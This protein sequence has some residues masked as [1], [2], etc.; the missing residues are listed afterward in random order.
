VYK[1]MSDALKRTGRP[2]VF[3]LCQY[4]VTSVWTWGAQAGGNLWRTSGDIEANYNSIIALGFGQNAGLERFAGPG[5]WN[6]PDMLE[7]GNGKLTAEE[8]RLHM[9]LWAMLAAPLL[10]GNDLAHMN[11]A[12]LSVLT[13]REVLAIDQDPLGVQGHRIWQDGPIDVWIKP[14]ADGSRAVGIF[15]KGDPQDPVTVQFRSLGI[16]KFA[17]VRD[18]WAEKDLGRFENSFTAAVPVHGVV[19]LRMR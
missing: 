6:D 19:L 5:H 3:S 9:S 7:V 1:K 8:N 10:A 18:L 11:P 4:G 15:N 14:L 2:I 16:G 17:Q 13:N 12:V